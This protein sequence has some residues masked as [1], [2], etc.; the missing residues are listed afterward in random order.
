MAYSPANQFPFSRA[1]SSPYQKELQWD[2]GKNPPQIANKI[3][4]NRNY[5]PWKNRPAIIGIEGYQPP[6]PWDLLVSCG[7]FWWMGS[8]QN[9]RGNV[10]VCDECPCFW[11]ST[12][13]PPPKKNEKMDIKLPYP[14][15][16]V[17]APFSAAR[18]ININSTPSKG[19]KLEISQVLDFHLWPPS[20]EVSIQRSDV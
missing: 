13:P 7:Y 16:V 11:T 15:S 2:F 14:I 17:V 8:S 9:S 20:F 6:V 5:P 12:P 1:I 3:H 4:A 19:R 18:S 10:R